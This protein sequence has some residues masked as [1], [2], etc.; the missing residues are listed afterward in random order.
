MFNLPKLIILALVALAVWYGYRAI[1]GEIGRVRSQLRKAKEEKNK[2]VNQV[3]P[4][5]K[6]KD[7][8]Y[9]IKDD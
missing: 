6:D 4:L 7:G 5:E 1:K 8:V 9:R 2:S 3:Q